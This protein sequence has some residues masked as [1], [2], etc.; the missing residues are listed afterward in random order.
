MGR[1]LGQAL[2]FA[3]LPGWFA[4][5]VVAGALLFMVAGKTSFMVVEKPDL[6]FCS[7]NLTSEA[8]DKCEAVL[9][10]TNGTKY[11]GEF[12]K[13][14]PNGVGEFVFTNEDRYAGEIRDGLPSGRGSLTYANGDTYVGS[15]SN[16]ELNGSG[17]L[18]LLGGGKYVGA[19]RGGLR[20]GQ[21]TFYY[22]DGSVYV[23]G[24]KNNMRNGRGTLTSASGA[25]YVGEFVDDR[26]DGKGTSYAADGSVLSDGVWDKD[27]FKGEITIKSVSGV[28]TFPVRFND[29]VTLDA[30]VDSG[31]A[32]VVVPDYVFKTL[33]NANTVT[34]NDLMG[35]STLI[36]ADGSK[37]ASQRFRIRSLQVG[38][39]VLENVEASTAPDNAPILLGQSALKKFSSWSIDNKRGTLVLK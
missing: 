38:N 9:T 27:K 32:N 8:W 39:R 22:R 28:Y 31:A 34:E 25:K 7:R 3:G 21:G 11:F 19:F 13:G 5:A 14:K 24:F 33:L 36:I 10:L 29:T 6:P 4:L 1:V 12:S 15:F 16:G 26:R 23:G 17:T 35:T 2:K 37:M 20:D 30:I 18:T